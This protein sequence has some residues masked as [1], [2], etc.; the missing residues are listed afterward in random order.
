MNHLELAAWLCGEFDNQAQSQD[1]PT[2][3]VPLRLWHR[4]LLHPIQGQFAIFAEQSNVLQLDKP[5]RQRVLVLQPEGD[6]LSVQFWAFR[7]PAQFR[8]AGVNPDLLLQ[9]TEAALEALPGCRLQVSELGDRYRAEPEPES[10]CCFPYDGKIRQVVLGFEASATQFL[11]YDRGV[12]PDTGQSL[13]GAMMGPYRHQKRCA[14]PLPN[15]ESLGSA[16]GA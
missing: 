15:L 7:D 9:A 5:Y 14:Y 6:R 16:V 13:W 11:S 12:D 3:Y 8:G 4:P 1:D 10:R 2:W